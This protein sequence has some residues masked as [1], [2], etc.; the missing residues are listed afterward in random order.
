MSASGKSAH[1]GR[2]FHSLLLIAESYGTLCG[3]ACLKP[4]PVPVSC[5][6]SS[7]PLPILSQPAYAT[8]ILGHK[9]ISLFDH[10]GF[11]YLLFLCGPFR[12]LC[13]LYPHLKTIKWSAKKNKKNKKKREKAWVVVVLPPPPEPIHGMAPSPPTTHFYVSHLS[14]WTILDCCSRQVRLLLKP[15]YSVPLARSVLF[16]ANTKHPH[17]DGGH[18]L[19]YINFCIYISLFFVKFGATPLWH[20][21]WNGTTVPPPP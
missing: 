5:T 20:F 10:S 12:S 19:K 15:F 9:F 13:S 2:C 16:E 3:P 1:L 18:H 11:T 6:K 4:G 17:H 14:L 21:L 8:H 7:E